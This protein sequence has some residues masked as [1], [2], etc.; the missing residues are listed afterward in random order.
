MTRR[1]PAPDPRLPRLA[2]LADLVQRHAVAAL[3]ENRRRDAALADEIAALR[4]ET[5][6]CE[7]TAF[8]RSGGAARRAVWR[9][10]RIRAL[11]AE[12]ARLRAARD[13]LARAAAR[14]VARDRVIGRLRDD[15]D[16]FG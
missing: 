8:E 1:G 10:K 4:A 2:A 6:G 12:R 11:N 3:A 9:D 14:A 7:P 15:S 5:A 16:P 13:G